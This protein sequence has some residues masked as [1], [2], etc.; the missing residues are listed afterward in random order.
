VVTPN[1]IYVDGSW[2]ASEGAGAIDVHDST[3]GEVFGSIAEGT[4]GDVDKAVAAARAA[5]PAWSALGVDE[6]AKLM[7]AAADAL[8]ERAE[9]LAAIITRETGMPRW[10]SE[11]IQVTMA[12]DD[13]RTAAEVAR[14]FAYEHEVGNSLVVHE[15]LGVVGCITPWNYPLH[16]IAAK[17]AYAM[18]AGCTVVVK[19]SE[20]APLDAIVLTEV[21]DALGLPPGVFN[22]VTGLGQVVGEAIAAHPDVDLVSFTGSGRA[23]QRVAEVAARNVT[24]VA[25]ELGG[26]SA[27]VLLDDLDD[28]TFEKAVRA[29]VGNCYL[30][31][32]QTCL[33]LTRMLVP[34]HRLAEAEAFAADEVARKFTPVDP[35]ADRARLGPLS[36]AAQV[37]RVTAYVRTG[38]DEG[39]KLVVGGPERPA[40]VDPDGYYVAPTV[41]SEV[42]NDMTIAREEIFGPVLSILPYDT[43]EDAVA[44]AND[45]EFGLGGGVWSADPDHAQAVARRLRAGQVAVNGGAFNPSA[46]FGGYKRSGYGREYGEYGFEE[47]LE[48]KSLQR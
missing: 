44:I 17:V 11:R 29:G 12:V 22:L 33:A 34:R 5:F 24:R 42:R 15:P 32:G 36:S 39:A 30:N 37:E 27:N 7:D 31:S 28:A 6:R 10:L 13:F 43:E 38:I 16:Q 3:N 35:F 26:K 20:V 40:D 25:L 23:G 47:F 8:Q 14:S 4:A 1:R 19:P 9:E 45:T 46:P 41:F 48:V 21:L 18:A 2:V